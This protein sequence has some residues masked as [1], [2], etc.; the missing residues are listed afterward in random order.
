MNLDVLTRNVGTNRNKLN[1]LFKFYYGI[2]VFDWLREQRMKKAAELLDKTSLN[3]M[4]ISERVGYPD[5]NNFSTAFKR[6][7]QLSPRQYRQKEK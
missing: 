5:S 2:S 4:Q 1:N 6:F 3:I 7:Y